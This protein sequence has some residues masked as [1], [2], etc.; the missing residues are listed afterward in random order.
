MDEQRIK[1]IETLV[2]TKSE[3]D[4]LF[5]KNITFITAGTLVLSLTFI[6][7]ITTLN[8]SV[9]IWTLIVSWSTLVFTLLINLVSHNI[10]SLYHEKTIIDFVKDDSRILVIKIE[11]R[12]KTLRCMNWT[13]T[14]SLT[15]GIIFLVIFCSINLY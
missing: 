14:I 5:E 15:I 6:E 4:S 13:T 3:S 9:A 1:D 8:S 2:K 7:K 10:S 12:N 11:K